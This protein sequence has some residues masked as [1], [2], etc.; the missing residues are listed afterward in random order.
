MKPVIFS[1][2]AVGALC[3]GLLFGAC[4]TLYGNDTLTIDTSNNTKGFAVVELFTSEGCSSCPPADKLLAT[5]AQQSNGKPLYVL[6]Y[7]VDYWDHQ[8]W[9]DAFSQ[10]KFSERQQ[11]YAQY[12]R[13]GV[14]TPQAVVNGSTEFIGSNAGDMQD[15]VGKALD[16]NGTYQLSLTGKVEAQQLTVNY[17]TNATGKA[18][19]VVAFVRKNGTSNVK[20]GE[21]VGRKL[22]HV[23]IVEQLTA[24]E[25]G[26]NR[27]IVLPLPAD[28]NAA[29]FELI[30]FV[31]RNQ[32][33]HI[34]A[35]AKIN[36]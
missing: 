31:Q 7:H 29:N 27:E 28:F 19:L 20:A 22:S 36:F 25:L 24:V 32:D 17:A 16:E 13:S 6:A 2:I 3:G 5:L 34:V 1:I 10:H 33:W 14:Y 35:A 12:L 4:N 23:Q 9:K 18:K 11:D 15:A 8:G 30:G 26:K 21:N